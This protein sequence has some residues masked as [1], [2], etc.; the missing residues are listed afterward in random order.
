MRSHQNDTSILNTLATVHHG[1]V[2]GH[3]RLEKVK[4]KRDGFQLNLRRITQL[5]HYGVQTIVHVRPDEMV[6]HLVVRWMATE[7]PNAQIADARDERLLTVD[8]PRGRIMI[9]GP[10]IRLR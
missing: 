2:D 9:Q 8:A 3:A 7:L 10:E 6:V 5:E 1:L 4:P